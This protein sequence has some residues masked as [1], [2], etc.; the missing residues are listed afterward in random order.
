MALR[1]CKEYKPE[2]QRTEERFQFAKRF[3]ECKNGRLK[4]RW[5]QR[6]LQTEAKRSCQFNEGSGHFEWAKRSGSAVEKSTW[7]ERYT[8][9]T[10]GK[11][12]KWAKRFSKAT[13]GSSS[14]AD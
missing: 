3:T 8:E 11:L 12:N 7:P 14:G 10:T 13:L 5:T 1:G 2:T 9:C 4:E 6:F